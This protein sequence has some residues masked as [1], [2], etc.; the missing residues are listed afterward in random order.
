MV[1][2]IQDSVALL[3]GNVDL[4]AVARFLVWASNDQC[5]IL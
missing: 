1:E 4:F 3:N 2:M 5:L